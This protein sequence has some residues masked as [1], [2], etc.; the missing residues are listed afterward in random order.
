MAIYRVGL[1]R[2]NVA[3]QRGAYRDVWLQKATRV[4]LELLSMVRAAAAQKWV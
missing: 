3:G 1:G 4:A 2:V